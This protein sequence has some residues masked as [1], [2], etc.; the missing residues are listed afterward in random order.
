MAGAGQDQPWN[1]PTE[2]ITTVATTKGISRN[3]G[4]CMTK[5]TIEDKVRRG[6]PQHRITMD[7]V[8]E[9]QMQ[10]V[11]NIIELKNKD[12]VEEDPTV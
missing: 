12:H 11:W 7:S 10:R 6:K 1:E 8:I 5:K 2:V 3:T 4:E 9:R